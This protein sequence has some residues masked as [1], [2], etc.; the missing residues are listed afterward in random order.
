MLLA[1]FNATA[2]VLVPLLSVVCLA[3]VSFVQLERQRPRRSAVPHLVLSLHVNTVLLLALLLEE[4]A[5]RLIGIPGYVVASL[6]IFLWVLYVSGADRK[7]WNTALVPSIL[8]SS[9]ALASW[10]TLMALLTGALVAMGWFLIG[11]T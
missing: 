2:K 7:I 6:F 10:L 3:G 9:G 11:A 5:N 4:V 1:G 8:R